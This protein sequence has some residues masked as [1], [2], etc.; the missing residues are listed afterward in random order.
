MAATTLAAI[1]TYFGATAATAAAVG[2][3]VVGAGVAGASAIGSA[4]AQ[5]RS[6]ALQQRQVDLQARRQRRQAIRQA[7]VQRARSL[8]Q[9]QAAGAAGGSAQGGIA[10]VSSQLGSGLGYASQQTALG[11]GVMSANQQAQNWATFGQLGGAVMN[12]GI[13]GGGL[14]GIFP[15]QAPNQAQ[16]P[17]YFP[18]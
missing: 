4:K 5:R 9:A 17:N 14:N 15:Q 13:Q 6:A 1:G 16:T 10:S 18:S 3:T 2:A 11:S 7:Q 8:A 12:F